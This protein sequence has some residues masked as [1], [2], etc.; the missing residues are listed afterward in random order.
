MFDEIYS[1]GEARSVAESKKRTASQVVVQ[2][3][4]PLKYY[5]PNRPLKTQL[6]A[7][8]YHFQLLDADMIDDLLDESIDTLQNQPRSLFMQ[9]LTLIFDGFKNAGDSYLEAVD[10]F[11]N[12]LSCNYLK[13]GFRLVGNKSENW[14][15]LIFDHKDGR[16]EAIFQCYIFCPNKDLH[17]G[18]EMVYLFPDI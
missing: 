18:G 11:C 5:P 13:K 12:V 8:L 4:L 15:D 10:G 9:H 14:M 3:E 7:V 1:P 6:D 2:L 17:P 16:V